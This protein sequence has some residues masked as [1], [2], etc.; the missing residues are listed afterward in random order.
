M[1]CMLITKLSSLKHEISSFTSH[2]NLIYFQF[3][4]LVMKKGNQ[5]LT[6]SKFLPRTFPCDT[7][8][9]SFLKRVPLGKLDKL[10]RKL[11]FIFFY[12]RF[13]FKTEVDGD[14]C[15]EE[16]TEDS[17]MVPLWEGKILVQCRLLD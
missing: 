7:S 9:S 12:F 6:E 16:E 8:R 14:M 3:T 11:E 1:P 15:Y 2:A 17:N 13:Y 10:I 4:P 5:C